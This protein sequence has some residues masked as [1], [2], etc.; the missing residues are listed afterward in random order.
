MDDFRDFTVLIDDDRYRVLSLRF[1]LARSEASAIQV[2]DRILAESEHHLGV[3][4]WTGDAL[5]YTTGPASQACD[6]VAR[7]SA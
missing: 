7:P 2:A 4:V 5:I 6:A 1:I 3:Q